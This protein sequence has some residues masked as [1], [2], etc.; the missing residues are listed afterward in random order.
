MLEQLEDWAD[1][2]R[3]EIQVQDISNGWLSKHMRCAKGSCIFHWIQ[4]HIEPDQKQAGI[5]CQKMLEKNLIG[6]IEDKSGR[7]FNINN[8][9][10]FYM[11]RDDIANNQVKRW[12]TEP[13]PALS[14]SINL[15]DLITEVYQ[16][17]F[18]ESMDDDGDE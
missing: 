14:V 9:Y 18:N 1:V 4:D 12:T 10:R 6:G 5:I 13:G 8:L 7:I 17:A 16:H 2:M 3:S 11:D 15:V